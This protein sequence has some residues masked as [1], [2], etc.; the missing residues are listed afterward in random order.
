MTFTVIA[1]FAVL[2]LFI[3]V[4]VEAVQQ[5]PQVEI[6]EEL[7]DVQDDMEELQEAQEDAAAVQQKILEEVRALRAEIAA[8]RG[9]APPSS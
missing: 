1:A 2:N 3:G 5:A 9:G 7:E 4:I 6:K 8:L